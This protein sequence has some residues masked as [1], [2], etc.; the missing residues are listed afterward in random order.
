[1]REPS[2][3]ESFAGHNMKCARDDPL[4]RFLDLE[5]AVGDNDEEDEDGEDEEGND[6]ASPGVRE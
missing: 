5:A 2:L 6:D 3:I 4:R 1:M